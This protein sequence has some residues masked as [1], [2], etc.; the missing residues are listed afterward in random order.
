[1]Y[2]KKY[3]TRAMYL[4]SRVSVYMWQV[5][6]KENGWKRKNTDACGRAEEESWKR[7]IE[8]AR[9]DK[10]LVVRHVW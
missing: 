4:L 9:G 8:E 6:R 10:A 2:Y 7:R 3:T 5:A 1:M